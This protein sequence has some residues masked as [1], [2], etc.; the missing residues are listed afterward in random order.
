MKA[1]LSSAVYGT[2]GYESSKVQEPVCFV[3]TKYLISLMIINKP[4]DGV[5]RIV[6]YICGEILINQIC[7]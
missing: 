7:R 3:Q 6:V 4:F 2:S 5:F 1:F